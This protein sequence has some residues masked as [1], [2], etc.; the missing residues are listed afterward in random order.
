MKKIKSSDLKMKIGIV[1]Y[2]FRKLIKE[3]VKKDYRAEAEEI[4][5]SFLTVWDDSCTYP[6]LV[7]FI[8]YHENKLGNQV[9]SHLDYMKY[10]LVEVNIM[11]NTGWFGSPYTDIN[12]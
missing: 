8:I 6:L 7:E 2:N 3:W 9:C 5:Y 11:K 4:I 1:E 12:L 10:R